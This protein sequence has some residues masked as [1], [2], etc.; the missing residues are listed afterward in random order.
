M[1]FHIQGKFQETYRESNQSHCAGVFYA[2]DMRDDLTGFLDHHGIA[3]AD[4]LSL[5]LFGVVQTGTRNRSPGK[6]HG[7]QICDRR[8]GSS[9]SNLYGDRIQ[10]RDR[11]IPLP[12]VGGCPART[13]RSRTKLLAVIESI[14]FDDQTV[15]FKIK[16]MQ[17]F[18]NRFTVS[19]SG[20]CLLY[21]SPSPRDRQKSRMP[22]SA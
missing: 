10:P 7:F 13:F 2:N 14:Q 1:P 15:N 22:S 16:L 5:N 19:G 9:F 6:L 18:D 12:F 8:D 17:G 3:H 20:L 11:F 4:I 21:T